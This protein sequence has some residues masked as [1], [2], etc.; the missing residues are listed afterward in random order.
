MVVVIIV[1]VV[2]ARRLLTVKIASIATVAIRNTKILLLV[3]LPVTWYHMPPQ[4]RGL[5]DTLAPSLPVDGVVV[6][7]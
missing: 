1:I 7:L 4:A 5:P 3:I 6:P 2:V